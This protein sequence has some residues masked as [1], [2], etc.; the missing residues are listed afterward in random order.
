[1]KRIIDVFAPRLGLLGGL[2]VILS[3]LWKFPVLDAL[4]IAVGA[5]LYY[6]R[7]HHDARKYGTILILAGVVALF[8]ML[9]LR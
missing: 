1:M 8:L 5:Y 3:L 9:L 4:G 6:H 2:C 7:E